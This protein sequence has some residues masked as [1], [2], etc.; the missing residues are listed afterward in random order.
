MKEETIKELL[1]QREELSD[2]IE[3]LKGTSYSG[4]RD[5]LIGNIRSLDEVLKEFARTI[6][7]HTLTSNK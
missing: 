6:T 2:K 1:R 4:T 3:R 7:P 5:A